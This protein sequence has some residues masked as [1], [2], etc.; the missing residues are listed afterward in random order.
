MTWR[1][2]RLIRFLISLFLFIVSLTIEPRIIT[3]G[4]ILDLTAL[5]TW[6]RTIGAEVE[7]LIKASWPLVLRMS[8][9]GDCLTLRRAF[10]R[11]VS[12]PNKPLLSV[13][14]SNPKPRGP[15]GRPYRRKE[16][17]VPIP[18]ED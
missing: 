9:D 5:P 3:S 8:G 10:G 12:C 18:V 13:G 15:S 1:S 6:Q 17:L 16:I 14:F 7:H 11:L 4:I 2:G